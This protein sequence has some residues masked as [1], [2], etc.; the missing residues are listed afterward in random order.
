MS[1]TS[2]RPL[3]IWLFAVFN[4]LFVTPWGLAS[5][6]SN[7]LQDEVT[8]DNPPYILALS[9]ASLLAIF[10]TWM[11]NRNSRTAMLILLTLVQLLLTLY[12]AVSV[13]AR[14]QVLEDGADVWPEF[15]IVF[16]GAAWVAANYWYFLGRRTRA[17]YSS[18]TSA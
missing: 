17:F 2:E 12:G 6:W 15:L 1:S 16:V 13:R 5:I 7:F 4:I 14:L 18:E 11:G 9:L 8:P 3:G 10:G